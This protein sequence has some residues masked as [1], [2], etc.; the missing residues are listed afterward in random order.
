MNGLNE[1]ISKGD[2]FIVNL[3]IYDPKYHD[4][5]KAQQGLRPGI[6]FSNDMACRFSP[7]LNI[8]PITSSTTKSNIPVHVVIG[9]TS[10]LL[11][12]SIALV[13]QEI[14]L[15]RMFLGNKIGH[16]TDDVIYKLE[17]A[18]RLQ[19][20]MINPFDYKK[21]YNLL[22]AINDA[23]KYI[24]KHQQHPKEVSFR[25]ALVGEFKNYCQQYGKDYK[26]IFND[27][28][29]SLINTKLN[30]VSVVNF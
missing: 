20:G 2:I 27:Y 29:E 11:K 5:M 25:N 28:K 18:A 30:N 12:E 19:R 7:I 4:K 10:G 26:E 15:D 24:K 22:S 3:D 9:K 8:I 21:A 14:A 1:P 6:V 13:E 23:D 17:E 16:C